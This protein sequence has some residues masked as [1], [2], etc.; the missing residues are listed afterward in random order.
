MGC[1]NAW[2]VR[3]LNEAKELLIGEMAIGMLMIITILL[4]FL[5]KYGMLHEYLPRGSFTH[6]PSFLATES[7]L[8]LTVL[9]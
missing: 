8:R 3:E 6:K 1:V 7:L 5:C 2:Q 4:N 9:R